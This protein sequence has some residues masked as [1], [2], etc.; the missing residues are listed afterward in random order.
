[1]ESE[2]KSARATLEA[3]RRLLSL[4]GLSNP[5]IQ[6]L[7]GDPGQLAEF[8][9][10]SPIDGI[11]VGV[12]IESGQSL[13]AGQAAFHVDDHSTLWA[14]VKIPVASLSQVKTGAE[15]VVR[16]QARQEQ[17]Y[18]GHLESLGGEVDPDSQTL[19]GRIVV[20]NRDGLLRPGMHAQIVL[21]GAAAKGLMVPA[22]AVFRMGDQTYVF[23]V[24]G[25]RRFQAMAVSTGP[26]MDGWIP[27]SGLTAGA[28]VVSGGVAEL[29]S[30]WQ[31]QGE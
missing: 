29:K 2:H 12:E 21:S 11:V 9:L 26:T 13:S 27:V 20:T 30:H 6:T 10:T 19:T 5:Q 22:S 3:R 18:R 15:A 8:D 4:A 23:K 25:P 14:V 17:P 31:Y 28:E 16:V 1:M 24:A 7:A